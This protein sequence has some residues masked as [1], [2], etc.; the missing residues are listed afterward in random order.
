MRHLLHLLTFSLILT[1]CGQS[2]VK[3][4]KK[5]G[6]KPKI[7]LKDN[8]NPNESTPLKKT[9]Q[10]K[11]NSDG[12]L[13]RMDL[14]RKAIG[15]W[16]AVTSAFNIGKYKIKQTDLHFKFNSDATG[17]LKSYV[18]VDI[19]SKVV[20][21]EIDFDIYPWGIVNN[22]HNVDIF[23]WSYKSG[24]LVNSNNSNESLCDDIAS[25]YIKALRKNGL[26]GN[27]SSFTNKSIILNSVQ[28]IYYYKNDLISKEYLL[29]IP[30]QSFK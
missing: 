24:K 18:D 19:N 17:K 26:D 25:K 4:K 5:N 28:P 16:Q 12:F 22:I 7:D 6:E 1:S 8:V 30:E 10:E 3:E 9:A 15:N 29:L 21:L 13:I 20:K 14:V 2:D 11:R 27:I 23:Y